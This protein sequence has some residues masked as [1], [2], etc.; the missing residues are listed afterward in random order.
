[1]A[2][3]DDRPTA[4]TKGLAVKSGAVQPWS[5]PTCGPVGEYNNPLTT[6]ELERLDEVIYEAELLTG[7]RFSVYLG[8]LGNST[9]TTAESLLD[10][11]GSDH[12][13]AVLVAVSPGQ[14]V[15]EV[16]TGTEAALRIS[17]RA[18]RLAVLSVVSSCTDG[19]LA[20]GLVNGVRVLAEQAGT[21][22][23]RVRW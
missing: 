17:D 7:L 12:A 20:G 16:V 9:R 13:H 21:L 23:E 2:H 8:D 18:A 10:G 19:D 5:A 15:V 4:D 3:G 1:V 6:V 14:K 22:P 11:L